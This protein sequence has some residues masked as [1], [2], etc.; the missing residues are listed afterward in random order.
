MDKSGQPRIIQ[1]AT[2]SEAEWVEAVLKRNKVVDVKQVLTYHFLNSRWAKDLQTPVH[3]APISTYLLIGA[4]EHSRVQFFQ[5]DFATI[6]T[7]SL[8]DLKFFV[9]SQEC[10]LFPRFYAVAKEEME[11]DIQVCLSNV[12]VSSF[13]ILCVLKSGGQV[14]GHHTSTMVVVSNGDRKTTIPEDAALR[15]LVR[16]DIFQK[17]AAQKIDLTK[18]PPKRAPDYVH[19]VQVRS[20]DLDSYSHVNH[21]VPLAY[22]FDAIDLAMLS[23]LYKSDDSRWKV[24]KQTWLKGPAASFHCIPWK[25]ILVVYDGQLTLRDESAFLSIWILDDLKGFFCFLTRQSKDGKPV[26]VTRI[27]LLFQETKSSL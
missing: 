9:R 17:Y 22:A 23:Q 2:M 16:S 8:G 7:P 18:L 24:L 25:Q 13:T 6:R 3:P 5:L 26:P 4:L 15:K 12:G 10:V 27:V 19:R 11:L 20:Q 1:V 14:L 21:S